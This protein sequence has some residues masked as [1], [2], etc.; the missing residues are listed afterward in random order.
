MIKMLVGMLLGAAVLAAARTQD[1]ASAPVRRVAS[2]SGISATQIGGV[3]DPRTG[4]VNGRW[5]ELRYGRPIRRGR[6]LFGAPDFVDFLNDGAP[7]W[8]AGA[9]VSTRLVTEAPLVIDKRRIPAGEY[10]LF[11]E[12][13]PKDRW[14]LI[15]S[16]WP[17]QTTYDEQNRTALWGAYEYT[18]DRDL[19]RAPMRVE[20]L[21]HALDQL[22]W[23]FLDVTDQSGRL[24]MMWERK[25]A[26]VAFTVE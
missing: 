25:L 26:S 7:V 21:P 13:A 12:L 24:A 8:R 18:P 16:S 15:V 5:L 6:D 19:V 17:A 22:S 11:I 1:P 3:F 2:P 9:N 14:T 23:Q 20:S 4:Y 10:T